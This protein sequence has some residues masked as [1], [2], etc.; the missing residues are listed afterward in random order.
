M[1]NRRNETH[2]WKFRVKDKIAN[3]SV[4]ALEERVQF[5]LEQMKLWFYG[6]KTLKD[7]KATIWGKKVD[8]RFHRSVGNAGR[9]VPCC[10]GASKKEKEDGVAFTETRSLCGFAENSGKGIGRTASRAS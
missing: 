6:Y 4:V 7:Y 5:S 3:L 1:E 9:T 8:F 2:G 10:S